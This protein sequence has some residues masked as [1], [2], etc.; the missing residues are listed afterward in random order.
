MPHFWVSAEMVHICVNVHMAHSCETTLVKRTQW[1]KNGLGEPQIFGDPIFENNGQRDD[2][3]PE[4][5]VLSIIDWPAGLSLT[6][7]QEGL[8]QSGLPRLKG[9]K[10]FLSPPNQQKTTR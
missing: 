10:T 8:A 9:E 3:T 7:F 6:S 4:K 5:I 2:A 1:G